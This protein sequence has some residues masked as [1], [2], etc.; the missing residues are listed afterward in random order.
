MI[1][2]AEQSPS[3]HLQAGGQNIWTV[4]ESHDVF[5][6]PDGDASER[7]FFKKMQ[8]GHLGGSVSEASHS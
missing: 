3:P 1:M 4:G 8:Q 7:Y 2:E 6:V 5:V